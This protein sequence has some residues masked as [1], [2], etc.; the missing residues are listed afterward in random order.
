MILRFLQCRLCG[1][2]AGGAW[3]CEDALVSCIVRVYVYVGCGIG[4]D[5]RL[6]ILL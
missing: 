2:G 6:L 4:I 3:E 1:V 5:A